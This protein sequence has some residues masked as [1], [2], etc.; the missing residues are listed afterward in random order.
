MRPLPLY[1]AWGAM[2]GSG[3]ATLIPFLCFFMLIVA[4]TTV[5]VAVAAL[6]GATYGAVRQ[7]VAVALAAGGDYDWIMS[8]YERLRPAAGRLDV[9]GLVLGAGVLVTLS[10][11]AT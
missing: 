10:V 5:P 11:A 3:V 7:A 1:F 9:A 6:A 2:L 4:E 8:T